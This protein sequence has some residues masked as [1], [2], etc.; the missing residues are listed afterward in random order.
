LSDP[1]T[2][3]EAIAAFGDYPADHPDTLQALLDADPDTISH[4][5]AWFL[6]KQG[7]EVRRSAEKHYVNSPKDA[8]KL[9]KNGYVLHP[10]T[11]KW[12][13][14]A[15]SENRQV[16]TV[17]HAKG[18]TTPMSRRTAIIPKAEDLPRLPTA[19]ARSTRRPAWLVIYGGNPEVLSKP[20]VAR[21]LATL[22]KRVDVA[23]VLFFS[24]DKQSGVPPT[25]WSVLAGHGMTETGAPGGQQVEFPDAEALQE[26]RRAA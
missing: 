17:P 15:L 1:R 13:A 11:D 7:L 2:L 10:W 6:R 9:L 25:L 8:L 16:I 19:A 26:V 24:R 18:G 22:R 12:V 5:L 4:P 3:A 23:D 21:G 14:Y 20:G